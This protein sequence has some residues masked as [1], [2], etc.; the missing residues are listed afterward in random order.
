M[1]KTPIMALTE[2]R[3]AP[4]STLDPDRFDIQRTNAGRQLREREYETM[5]IRAHRPMLRPAVI[6][7][8]KPL[9]RSAA[10]IIF[11]RTSLRQK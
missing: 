11:R 5:G 10:P 7:A 4:S 6:F 9:R 2:G 8:M 3:K 1:L